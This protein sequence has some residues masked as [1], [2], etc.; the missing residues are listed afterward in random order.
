MIPYTHEGL[1]F[2]KEYQMVCG[3]VKM[4]VRRL[5]L[6][7][8]LSLAL[9]VT[10]IP[11]MSFG[12]TPNAQHGT[13]DIDGWTPGEGGLVWTDPDTGAKAEL[14]CENGFANNGCVA[15]VGDTVIFNISNVPEGMYISGVFLNGYGVDYDDDTGYYSFSVAADEEESVGNVIEINL[16][17]ELT[18]DECG[19]VVVGG[20]DW[21]LVPESGGTQWRTE[22]GAYIYIDGDIYTFDED[23]YAHVPIGY[24]VN[25]SVEPPEG[26]WVGS[27]KANGTECEKDNDEEWTYYFDAVADKEDESGNDIPGNVITVDFVEEYTFDALDEAAKASA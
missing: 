2:V 16:R 13:I 22:E 11:I 6:C 14:S 27:L 15:D 17:N 7:M 5:V 26:K 23:D 12:Y 18:I 8:M 25:V 3:G 20:D 1:T 10:F 9:V 24:A 21:E 19:T 4:K